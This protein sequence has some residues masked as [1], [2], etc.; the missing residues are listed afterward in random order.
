MWCQ[1]GLCCLLWEGAC[2]CLGKLLWRPT[3]LEGANACKFIEVRCAV[4]KLGGELWICTGSHRY[5]C[6]QAGAGEG[7]GDCQLFCSQVRLTKIFPP[8]VH[9]LKLV[10]NLPPV[11]PRYFSNYMLYLIGAVYCAVSLRVRTQFPS[12]LSSFRAK[13]T[14]F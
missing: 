5:L 12:A 8:P 4:S 3:G 6:I 7:N 11:Y 13:S 1:Q 9:P 14:D 10:N 2:C